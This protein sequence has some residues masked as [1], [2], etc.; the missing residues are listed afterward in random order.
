M[1]GTNRNAGRPGPP[2]GESGFVLAA[3]MSSPTPVVTKQE[4][5][6]PVNNHHGHMAY[7]PEETEAAL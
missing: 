7:V 5:V 1:D 4:D 6:S 2:A 3:R